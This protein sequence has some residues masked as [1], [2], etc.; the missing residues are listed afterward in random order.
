MKKFI[1]FLL[2][3]LVV[4]SRSIPIIGGSTVERKTT[5][6]NLHAA[7]DKLQLL[8]EDYVSRFLQNSTSALLADLDRVLDDE[9]K[10]VDEE[11]EPKLILIRLF[12]HKIKIKMLKFKEKVQKHPRKR[13]LL[14]NMFN[15]ATAT[16]ALSIGSAALD[17]ALNHVHG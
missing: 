3:T 17:F 8:F 13:N 7:T 6:E 12:F 11:A 5:E 16:T 15:L 4:G 1:V 14:F 9:T 10:F 2:T